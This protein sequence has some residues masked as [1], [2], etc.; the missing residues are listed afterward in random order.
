MQ[1][2]PRLQPVT[3]RNLNSLRRAGFTSSECLNICTEHHG[4]STRLAYS[5]AL[6]LALLDPSCHII[7]KPK[8]A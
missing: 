8:R 5:V 2:K 7:G 3:V 1:P 4:A 6:T